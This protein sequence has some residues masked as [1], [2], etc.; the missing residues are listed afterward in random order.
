MK[1]RIEKITEKQLI[2]ILFVA[3]FIISLTVFLS[4]VITGKKPSIPYISGTTLTYFGNKDNYILDKMKD[5]EGILSGKYYKFSI[6]NSKHKNEIVKYTTYIKELENN[7]INSSDIKVYL[8]DANNVPQKDFRSKTHKIITPDNQEKDYD[9][10]DLYTIEIKDTMGDVKE[11]GETKNPKFE[12]YKFY[13]LNVLNKALNTPFLVEEN[14]ECLSYDLTDNLKEPRLKDSCSIKL[15]S[16]DKNYESYKLVSEQG[17]VLYI[18]DATSYKGTYTKVDDAEFNGDIASYIISKRHMKNNKFNIKHITGIKQN[19]NDENFSYYTGEVCYEHKI[20]SSEYDY[21][22][23]SV[24]QVVSLD[25]CPN[26]YKIV[27]YEAKAISLGDLDENYQEEDISLLT[28]QIT[29][30]IDQ[31]Y[32]IYED[33]ELISDYSN[34]YYETDFNKQKK[35]DYRLRYWIDENSNIKDANS[36]NFRINVLSNK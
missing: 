7:T 6:E 24:E 15:M 33:D 10:Y 14:G 20:L 35:R 3:I 17:K 30:I 19:E 2:I 36:F 22:I 29:N 9:Y 13:Q 4:S 27:D 18:L 16:N 26:D 12:L 8:T 23:S 31:N 28:N 5:Y 34:N 1:N 25:K 32:F 11:A 21:K